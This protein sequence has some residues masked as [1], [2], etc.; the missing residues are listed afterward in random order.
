MSSARQGPSPERADGRRNKQLILDAAWNALAQNPQASIGEIAERAGLTRATVYRH[1]PDRD[2]LFRAVAAEGAS[3]L[4]PALLDA[5]RPLAWNDA[6][7]LLATQAVRLGAEYRELI[8]LIAPRL[9]ESA[10][11]AV[12]GEP[13]EA[14]IAMRRA[15]GEITSPLTD[16]WLALCI[17]TL[18]LAAISRLTDPELDLDETTTQ[19]GLSLRNLSA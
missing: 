11:H 2:V 17:R 6:L 1:Y 9:E 19:L 5:L 16:A 15:S 12:E 4:I 3:Q 13:I 8:M 18:C 7:D 10:R 14:E